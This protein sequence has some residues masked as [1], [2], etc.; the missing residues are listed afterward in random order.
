MVVVGALFITFQLYVNIYR[1]AHQESDYF[2]LLRSHA[3]RVPLRKDLS[4]MEFPIYT[5]FPLA[6]RYFNQGVRYLA[7]FNFAYAV[8]SFRQGQQLDEGCC[9]CYWGEAYAM[10]R[11]LNSPAKADA[12]PVVKKAVGRARMCAAELAAQKGKGMQMVELVDRDLDM[13]SALDKRYG[14]SW[15]DQTESGRTYDIAYAEAMESVAARYNADPNVLMFAA[16]AQM[17]TSPWDYWED[18]GLTMK[19]AGAKAHE[20]IKRALAIA[21]D[22]PGLI[23]LFIHITEASKH[24]EEALPYAQRLSKLFPGGPHLQHMPS[25]TFMRVGDYH[26]S[27]IANEKALHINLTEHV[28]PMHN[29]EFLVFSLRMGG[30]HVQALRASRTLSLYAEQHLDEPPESGFPTERFVV[31]EILT[32]VFFAQWQDVLA[33]PS[34]P[35]R[36]PYW[37]AVWHFCRAIALLYN[38]EPM[39]GIPNN[40]G[41]G[42]MGETVAGETREFGLRKETVQE[43]EAQYLPQNWPVRNLLRMFELVLSAHTKMVEGGGQH[44]EEAVR[45]LKQ[46]SELEA[47]LPY[48]EPPSFFIPI[49]HYLG[50]ALMDVESYEGAREV[51]EESLRTFKHDG[52]ALFGLA[53]ACDALQD[54]LCSKNAMSDFDTQ[55]MYADVEIL[56]SYTVNPERAFDSVGSVFQVMV[57][58]TW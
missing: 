22:H 11:N 28:Y 24:P 44:H 58:S 30:D 34:P 53:K 19:P 51:Y 45:L 35:E 54:T 36:Y 26:N 41:S 7:T 38:G 32:Q 15:A 3:I 50:K 12:F 49:S 40:Q 33:A 31:A 29:M 1:G 4:S 57:A 42:F 6:Q 52:W 20:Y 56:D 47:A 48:D 25:H 39:V 17:N 23:H 18:D 2:S 43:R 21:P 10:G 9:M 27:A 55:W 13:I 46:A 16:D 37:C 14:D 5:H 8:E